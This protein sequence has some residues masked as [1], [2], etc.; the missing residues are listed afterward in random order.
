MSIKCAVVGLGH[1]GWT[2]SS[3]IGTI[4]GVELV[5]ACDVFEKARNVYR[6]K[7]PGV[8]IY[9]SVPE[10]LNYMDFDAAFVLTSDPCHM[11][12]FI[13]CLDAGK[14]VFVEKPVANRIEDI[15]EMVRAI[16]KH[17]D[18]IAAS[19]HILRYYPVNQKIKQ[20]A[21][22]REF[23]DIFYMEGDYIHNLI[24]QASPEKFNESLGRNWYTE[25]E[26]PMVGGG[27]HPFDVL[28]WVAD[29]PVVSVSSMG[30]HIAFPAMKHEDCIVSIYKFE[31][32]AVAKVTALYGPVAPYAAFNNIAIYGTKASVWRDQVCFDH[33]EGWKPLEYQTYEEK[34]SHG[35][36][37]EIIDFANAIRTGQPV[38]APARD[39]A[40]SEIATLVAT[41]ALNAGKELA[42][43][44]LSKSLY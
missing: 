42:I 39:C 24:Y 44:Q 6:D 30:N 2:Y 43:P 14:H 9:S 25:D 18:L 36:E 15:V 33:E 40:Q 3:A 7:F 19:G 38:I 10:L 20:M 32:G 1:V 16:D 8:P 34:F 41:D 21:V 11:E 4:G 29:S 28:A 26:K 27:C 22:N 17:P 37:R 31:S 12:P 35:F 13:Q 23:G 5:A